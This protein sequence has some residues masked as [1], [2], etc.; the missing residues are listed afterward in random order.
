M[1]TAMLLG[2][3]GGGGGSSGAGATAPAGT[4]GDAGGSAGGNGGSGSTAVAKSYTLVMN[5]TSGQVGVGSTLSL[6]ASVVDDLGNDVTGAT[7]FVWTSG[8]GSVAAVANGT[9][10]GSAVVTGVGVGTTAVNVAATVAGANGTTTVLPQVAATITVVAPGARTYS[11]ALPYPVLSMTN[12]QVLPVTAS[13]IDSDGA[14]RSGAATGWTWRSST[15][16]VQATGSTNV[17][18]LRGVNTSDTTAQSVVTVQVTAPDGNT[19]TGAFLVSVFKTSVSTYR[20]VLSQYGKQINALNVLNG[21]PQ[22]YDSRVLRND[23]SDATADFTGL[24]TYMTTSPSLAVVPNASTRVTTV[25]TSRPT[26]IAPLQSVLEEMAGS[27]T[28]TA[29]PRAQLLVTEQPTWG[30]IYSGPSP[31]IVPN[32]GAPVS[33]HLLHRGIDEGV[34]GCNGTWNW[35]VGSGPVSIVPHGGNLA[36]VVPSGSGPFTVIVSCTAGTEAMPVSLTIPGVA[37]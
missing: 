21:Y 20:L 1:A 5:R 7:T 12:G 16:A 27:L 2:A 6:T 29:K 23:E 18:T 22:T 36:S 31:F 35:Q 3:C 26:G 19:L 4:G 32:G 28:L 34:T 15:T 37:Q 25:S 30:L 17:G 11:L 9:I 24:W 33:A 10:P 8:N 14:D 13:L